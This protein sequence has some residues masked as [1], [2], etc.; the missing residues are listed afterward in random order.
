[1]SINNCTISLLQIK[2]VAVTK[3]LEE[4]TQI[5]AEVMFR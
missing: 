5:L 1:M 2:D 4:D 3:L